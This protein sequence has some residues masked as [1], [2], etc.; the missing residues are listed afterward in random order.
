MAV[1]AILD[2][3]IFEFWTVGRVTSN[4]KPL[5]WNIAPKISETKQYIIMQP[6]AEQAGIPMKLFI[7]E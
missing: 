7:F 5:V 2:F 4:S 1:V 6:Y 3:Q